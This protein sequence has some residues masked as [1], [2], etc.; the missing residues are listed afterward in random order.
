MNRFIDTVFS[1]LFPHRCA[2]CGRV[3]PSDKFV[4]DECKKNLPRIVDPI[5]EKCGRGKDKCI[6]K[7][8]QKYFKSIVAPFYYSGI[9]RDGVHAFKFR[10]RIANAEEYGSEMSNTVIERYR[11]ISFDF[12][13][14]VPLTDKSRRERG[15]NQCELLAE[16]ISKKLGVEFRKNVIVK[17]FDTHK[18]HRI[19]PALRRG[20]LIGAFDVLVPSDVEGKVI[21]L[22]DDICTTGETLNECSKMLWL[23]GAKEIYCVS[24]ALTLPKNKKNIIH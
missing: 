5:C 1:A 24:L 21:L 8:A 23:Y 14:T 15:Y 22:C 4:C 3:V 2:Y 9:V 16:N 12:I 18:Q 17:I 6:C 11:D 10:H 13:T 7:K 20:N 19:S